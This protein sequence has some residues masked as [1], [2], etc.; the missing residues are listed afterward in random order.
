M[1]ATQDSAGIR[2]LVEH[3]ANIGALDAS[4]S[5]QISSALELETLTL[6]DLVRPHLPTA[7]P[8][9]ARVADVHAASLASGHLRILVG[10][11]RR[12]QGVV[13]VRDTLGSTPSASIE[14]VTRAVL[15]LP[16]D[17]TVYSALAR[18]REANQQLAVINDGSRTRQVGL[19]KVAD[20]VQHLLPRG[21][22][23]EAARPAS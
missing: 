22:A 10:D 15:S 12:I 21:T 3:S 5:A 11:P 18:M 17:T 9:G 7:V 23:K 20:L 6:V 13:H 2:Q 8:E 14:D 4:Y 19:L 16:A 1:A